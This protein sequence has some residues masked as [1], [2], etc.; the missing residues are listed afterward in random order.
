[1]YSYLSWAVYLRQFFNVATSDN[2]T[3][4]I[5]EMFASGWKSTWSFDTACSAIAWQGD[6]FWA[7]KRF[8]IVATVVACAQL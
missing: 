3:T 6:N 5:R 8:F 1:M 2:E 7:L 4:K